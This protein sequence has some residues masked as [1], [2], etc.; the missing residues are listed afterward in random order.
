MSDVIITTDAAT[1][2]FS[3]GYEDVYIEDGHFL[4]V[5]EDP[6]AWGRGFACN[7]YFVPGLDA[8]GAHDINALELWRGDT[9]EASADYLRT[10][11]HAPLDVARAVIMCETRRALGFEDMGDDEKAAYLEYTR[12]RL[13]DE[14]AALS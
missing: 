10:L 4:Y 12:N 11:D 9:C 2:R 1:L 8:R 5:C 3:D 6:G 14:I 13:E 7:E